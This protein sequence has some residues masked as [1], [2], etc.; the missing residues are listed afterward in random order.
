MSGE[1]VFSLR[2]AGE[3]FAVSFPTAVLNVPLTVSLLSPPLLPPPACDCDPQGSVSS[4]CDVRGGQCR[5]R[6]N[7]I[8]RRCDQCAPGTYGFGPSGC[9]GEIFT[10]LTLSEKN[11]KELPQL[12]Q[13][14]LQNFL[15]SVILK[16]L[17]PSFPISVLQP[18]VA[19]WR[20]PCRASAT[21][22]PACAS[23]GPERSASAATAARRVTGASP[24]AGR[25]SATGTRSSASRGRAPA[26]VAGT[27]PA[28]TS[29]TG[30]V[31][32]RGRQQRQKEEEEGRYLHNLALCLQ[33]RRRLLWQPRVGPHVRQP[34]PAVPV[35]RGAQ[36]RP[37]LCCFLLPGRPEQADRLQL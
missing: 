11:K 32:A 34:V 14:V 29:V 12:Q 1:G 35:S 20:A 17:L 8:G 9:I 37:P 10:Q 6:P 5:C 2:S 26:S 25:A 18:A 23:V 24:A 33:V 30:E 28:G 16:N 21:S 31:A 22:S 36:Q 4:L 15:A 13:F 7:V 19:A 27:T 3:C